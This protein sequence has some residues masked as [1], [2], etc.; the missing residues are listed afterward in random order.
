MADPIAVTLRPLCHAVYELGETHMVSS[1]AAGTR[2]ISGITSVRYEGERFKASAIGGANADWATIDPDG[3]VLVDVRLTLRTD[4]GAIVHVHYQ[5]RGDAATG[6]TCA[7]PLFETGD[8]R[9][10]WLTRIQAVG[11]SVFDGTKLEYEIFEVA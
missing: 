11:K 9:Y 2:L 1:G 5:G 7:A 3:R 10:A 6:V 4:D 8:E